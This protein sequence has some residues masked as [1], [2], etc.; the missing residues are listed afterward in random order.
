MATAV[1]Q[2]P[3]DTASVTAQIT[4]H[5]MLNPPNCTVTRDSRGMMFKICHDQAEI[6]PV[7]RFYSRIALPQRVSR[8]HRTLI[9]L[10]PTESSGASGRALSQREVQ[11]LGSV[12]VD[13]DCPKLQFVPRRQ[14]D[15]SASKIAWSVKAALAPSPESAQTAIWLT[16]L[17]R[18]LTPRQRWLDRPQ[19]C[20]GRGPTLVI[21]IN[22]NNS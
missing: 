20:K 16:R 3:T 15:F 19:N 17:Q 11:E 6:S 12:R 2:T 8:G 14:S 7:Q 13:C 9:K 10:P 1:A 18:R 5:I 22:F 4:S 21:E